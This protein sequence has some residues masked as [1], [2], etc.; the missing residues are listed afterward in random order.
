MSNSVQP[1]A[2]RLCG[3]GDV[4]CLGVIPPG[5]FFAGRVLSEPLA[6]GRL[7]RCR[8]CASLFRHPVLSDAEYLKL[9][10]TGAAEQWS[11]GGDR[12][13][14]RHIRS[15]IASRPGVRNVLDV[16]CGTGDF[17]ASLP[18]AIGKFGIE[19]S[20][21]AA[22][23]ASV[24]GVR[25]VS[26][27]QELAESARFDVITLIDVIEH[28]RQPALLLD[29]ALQHLSPGGAIV[30][31][32]GDP[33]CA[34]WR[35]FRSRFWYSSFPEH[36]SF[37]SSRFFETWLA[38]KGIGTV[39]TRR[40]RNLRLSPGLWCAFWVVQAGYAVSPFLFHRVGRV[41]GLF[42]W[43]LPRR[44]HACPAAPGVFVDHQVV[45]IQPGA[46]PDGRANRKSA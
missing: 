34:A 37:P 8:G 43:L 16:G 15:I 21:A 4:E 40:T 19:P 30:V 35:I 5:D 10:E 2:C 26:P 31:S 13:D 29:L 25:I 18:A 41:A 14:L 17:L 33:Q 38:A 7:W 27:L 22:E 11:D 1:A 12:N 6:G 24:R 32:T 42:G 44:R 28:L 20:V 36:V 39:E 45:I 3:A 46:A 9:Y 23:R